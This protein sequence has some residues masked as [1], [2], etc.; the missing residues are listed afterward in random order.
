[1]VAVHAVRGIPLRGNRVDLG[2]VDRLDEATSTYCPPQIRSIKCDLLLPR[3]V[4]ATVGYGRRSLA[5]PKRRT[6]ICPAS[7][8]LCAAGTGQS[9]ADDCRSRGHRACAAGAP[10]ECRFVATDN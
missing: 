8:Y 6:G 4:S 1:M 7:D 3:G 10:S 2:V 9:N 5:T